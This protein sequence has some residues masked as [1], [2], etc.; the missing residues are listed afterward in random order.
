MANRY[1]QPQS[2]TYLAVHAKLGGEAKSI[3]I[4]V[5]VFSQAS[6]D[7]D[8]GDIIYPSYDGEHL[9]FLSPY[10]SSV[11][12]WKNI[13]PIGDRNIETSPKLT[14]VDP[15]DDQNYV[16]LDTSI[17]YSARY[18]HYY[19]SAATSAY[20]SVFTEE[21]HYGQN[22][23]YSYSGMMLAVF[24]D[25]VA[26]LAYWKNVWNFSAPPDSYTSVIAATV[27]DFGYVIVDISSELAYAP[28]QE[29]NGFKIK[30]LSGVTLDSVRMGEIVYKN[31]FVIS[32][33]P[34]SNFPNPGE[35][36][37]GGD[38][39]PGSGGAGDAIGIPATPG[40]SAADTG[41]ITL[42]SPTLLQ[43]QNLASYMWSGAFDLESFRK[44]FADPMDC[45][46]GLS[47]VPCTVP[48]GA[49]RDIRVGNI[50][51]GVLVSTAANNF[52]EV[53][54]GTITVT[55]EFNSYLDYAP[56]TT[57][58]VFL[59]YIGVHH[60]DTDNIMPSGSEVSRSIHIVY[61]IDLFTGGCVAF[62]KC[63]DSVMYSFT[64][65]CSTSVPV[66]GNNWTEFYKAITNIATAAIGTISAGG[67][68]FGSH[69]IS[70]AKSNVHSHISDMESYKGSHSGSLSASSL[71]DAV[72]SAK[73]QIERSGVM[74]SSIGMLGI[75]KPYL[76]VRRPVL[77][78]PYGANKYI[79]YPSNL[80][81]TLSSLS[82][83]TI[84]EE[85]HLEHIPATEDEVDEIYSLL[86]SG[87]II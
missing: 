37:P 80:I 49:I 48:K 14:I 34:Y 73:P 53:D 62:I 4:P 17:S 46:L 63:A 65:Q 25:G 24:S 31:L 26:S 82:G 57:I 86:K 58:D 45:I 21:V 15:A 72:F 52:I 44:I 79:G 56:F 54:C 29:T 55:R 10:Q 69:G 83:P 71:A 13:S 28:M 70:G 43:L 12:C 33:D 11:L 16:R 1:I 75:Q 61:K 74:G 59:P 85:V 35:E 81:R 20:Y 84:M 67:A 64:G 66:T 60:L 36:F 32:T 8:N 77:C 51:T 41:F 22:N 38:G 6:T 39:S 30:S 7:F 23:Y 2:V 5:V 27:T 47:I 9:G 19:L 3:T 42:Y 78:M 50:S 40:I 68:S 87:V 76:I 18:V